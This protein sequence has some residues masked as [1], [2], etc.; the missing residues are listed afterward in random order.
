[1]AEYGPH[2]SNSQEGL[3]ITLFAG[4]LAIWVAALA[5]ATPVLQVIL[6]IVGVAMHAASLVVFRRAKVAGDLAR[7]TRG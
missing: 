4:G 2:D 6:V 3:A 1:M 7:G 5:Y